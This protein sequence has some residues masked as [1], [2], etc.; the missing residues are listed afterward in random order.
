MKQ[1]KQCLF[2]FSTG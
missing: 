1:T 2:Q